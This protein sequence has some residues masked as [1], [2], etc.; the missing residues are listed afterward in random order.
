MV[1]HGMRRLKVDVSWDLP[2]F[3]ASVAWCVLTAVPAQDEAFIVRVAVV[4]SRNLRSSFSSLDFRG[5]W[6]DFSRLR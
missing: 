3:S 1:I 6:S 4:D 5:N 2:A